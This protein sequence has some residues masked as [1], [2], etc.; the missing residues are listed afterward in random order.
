MKIYP[1]I[2]L[3]GGNVVRLVRGDY[4]RMSV[5]GDKP[6]DTA[7]WLRDMGARQLHVVDLDGALQGQAVNI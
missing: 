2:D 5:Y 1:A 3:R 4:D 7:L 6:G